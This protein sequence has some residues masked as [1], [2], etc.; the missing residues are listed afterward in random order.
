MIVYWSLIGNTRKLVHKLETKS[1]ELNWDNCLDLVVEEPFLLVTPTYAKESTDL[2][3]DF[4]DH[5]QN[6]AFCRGIIGTGNRNFASL[7]CYTAKD[8]SRDYGIPLIHL[9]EFQGSEYDIKRINEELGK[10]G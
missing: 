2:L 3:W 1:L 4:L 10:I 5:E 8:L 6:Q 7:F 9:L